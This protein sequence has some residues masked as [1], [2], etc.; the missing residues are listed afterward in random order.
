MNWNELFKN[1]ENHWLAPAQLVL[2]SI[3]LFKNEFCL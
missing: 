1:K 3:E 2:D